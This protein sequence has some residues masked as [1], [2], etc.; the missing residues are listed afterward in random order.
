MAIFEIEDKVK[1]SDGSYGY[2]TCII[3]N[4]RTPGSA[5]LY[6]VHMGNGSVTWWT[7]FGLEEV[8]EEND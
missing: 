3:E 4:K 8:E 7:K 2:V 6:A 1:T 5:E